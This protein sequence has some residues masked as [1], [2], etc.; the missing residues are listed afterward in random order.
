MIVWRDIHRLSGKEF[1]QRC[2]LE[3]RDADDL[4]DFVQ[5]WFQ[6]PGLLQY[7]DEQAGAHRGPDLNA[8]RVRG[9]A[10]EMADAKVLFDPAEEQFD[11]PAGAIQLGDLEGRGGEQIGEK[12]QRAR[13]HRIAIA[14]PPQRR[15]VAPLRRVAAQLNGLIAVEPRAGHG[16]SA[17]L[18]INP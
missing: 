8:H 18:Y 1:R 13:V 14:D 7:G 11:L 16:E 15:R 2:F 6:L 4:K 5:T 10:D 17:H 12:D 9:I 3:W